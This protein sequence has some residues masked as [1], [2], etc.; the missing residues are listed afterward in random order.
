MQAGHGVV[1]LLLTHHRPWGS[2]AQEWVVGYE[3]RG[4]LIVGQKLGCQVHQP[5]VMLVVLEPSHNLTLSSSKHLAYHQICSETLHVCKC[6]TSF[7]LL[8]LENI[9]AG[10]A[11]FTKTYFGCCL[12]TIKRY[13]FVFLLSLQKERVNTVEK[14]LMCY[15]SFFTSCQPTLIS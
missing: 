1:R 13:G 6:T 4:P 10:T 11:R 14:H 5:G 8:K 2:L 12:F 3:R 7:S 9:T 15:L